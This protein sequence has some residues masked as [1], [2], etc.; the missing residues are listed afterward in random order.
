MLCRMCLNPFLNAIYPNWKGAVSGCLV[1]NIFPDKGWGLMPSEAW[2]PST[3]IS[4]G[5][6]TP[7]ID[8]EIQV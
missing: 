6:L 7:G 4:L 5:P 1:E 2:V 8:T 3:F